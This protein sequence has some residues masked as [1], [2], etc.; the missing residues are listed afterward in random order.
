MFAAETELI[1]AFTATTSPIRVTE[2]VDQS[3]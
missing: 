1:P 2:S 3:T